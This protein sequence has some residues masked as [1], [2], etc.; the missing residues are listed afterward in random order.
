MFSRILRGVF[1]NKILKS[2]HS[3]LICL[4]VPYLIYKYKDAY[5]LSNPSYYCLGVEKTSIPTIFD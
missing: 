1:K 3:K 5:N 2:N 4:A